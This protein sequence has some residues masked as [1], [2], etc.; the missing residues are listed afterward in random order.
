MISFISLL[1]LGGTFFAAVS[2]IG[3][4]RLP[5]LYSRLHAASKSSTF[6]VMLMMLGTFFYFWYMDNYIDSKLFLAILFIFVTAPV[7]AHVV[8]RSAFH[9][10]VEPYKLTILNELKRD[11]TGVDDFAEYTAPS[12]QATKRS[13]D[14]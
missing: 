13:N 9:S 10:D 11:E 3:V 8:S 14:D 6:G 12:Y 5:D 2:A 7:S 1:I 4:V